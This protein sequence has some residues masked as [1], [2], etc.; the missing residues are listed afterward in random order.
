MVDTK[1]TERG[2][3]EALFPQRK[4]E[5]GGPCSARNTQISSQSVTQ[6]LTQVGTQPPQAG[7]VNAG[8]LA[9]WQ[10]KQRRTPPE[11]SGGKEQP[12][13]ILTSIVEKE[14]EVTRCGVEA[15]C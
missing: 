12:E 14:D 5:R 7:R 8:K 9:K 1:K 10:E 2:G 11:L 4:E 15:W 3:G 13:R 6:T